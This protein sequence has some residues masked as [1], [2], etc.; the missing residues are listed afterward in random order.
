MTEFLRDVTDAF[1]LGCPASRHAVRD[2]FAQLQIAVPPSTLPADAEPAEQTYTLL[3]Y[4]DDS[5]G[6]VSFLIYTDEALPGALGAA[7]ELLNGRAAADPSD[8]GGG[9]QAFALARIVALTN[10]GLNCAEWV[11]EEV[12][13]IGWPDQAELDALS[14]IRAAASFVVN[15]GGA[16]W[17]LGPKP[18]DDLLDR[19]YSRV[20]SFQLMS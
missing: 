12:G 1:A 14:E 13:A 7:L 20:V 11:G 17:A 19:T 6:Q 4:A 5:A 8:V 3:A 15:D 9:A 2:A 16:I 18:P 10:S